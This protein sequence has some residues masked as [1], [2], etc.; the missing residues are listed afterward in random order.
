[1]EHLKLGESGSLGSLDGLSTMD[2]VMGD[3]DSQ[4]LQGGQRRS[5]LL[6]R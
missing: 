6:P 2:L 4:H 5:T 3:P 1:M